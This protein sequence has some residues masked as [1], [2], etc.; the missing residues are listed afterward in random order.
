M[1][2]L[3]G[4]PNIQ[5]AVTGSGIYVG[6]DSLTITFP[7]VFVAGDSWGITVDGTL[8][9]TTFSTTS[10]V[11]LA[12]I[13]ADFVALTGT[14]GG[15]Y[16][17]KHTT[18]PRIIVNGNQ[19][20]HTIA[21]T[22]PTGTADLKDSTVITHSGI[23]ELGLVVSTPFDLLQ[24]LIVDSNTAN[25][26]YTAYALPG[27]VSTAPVWAVKRA[28]TAANVVTTTWADGNTNNDNK[29]NNLSGLT[30]S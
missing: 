14:I 13:L 28:V 9:T 17:V 16:I 1:S 22:L 19:I 11:M 6:K 24:P 2:L 29:A 8:T 25:T 5:A 10:D 7:R 26:V 12:D 18:N 21:L 4:S 3:N 27:S 23:T 20:G 30:Y 15:G